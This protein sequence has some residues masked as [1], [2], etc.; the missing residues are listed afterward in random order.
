MQGLVILAKG[1]RLCE[2]L[3]EEVTG[4]DTFQFGRELPQDLS[5]SRS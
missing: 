2:E 3:T 4:D 1:L 5:S